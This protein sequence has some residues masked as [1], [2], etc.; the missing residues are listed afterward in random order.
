MPALL[1]FGGHLWGGLPYTIAVIVI[2]GVVL[3][4]R[5]RRGEYRKRQ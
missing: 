1:A 3:W 5:Y 2:G 4:I